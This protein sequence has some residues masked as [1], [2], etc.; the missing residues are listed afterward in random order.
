MSLISGSDWSFVILLLIVILSAL[1]LMVISCMVR[2]ETTTMAKTTEI[3]NKILQ[4][5]EEGKHLL[6]NSNKPF[7][8]NMTMR[9]TRKRK[10]VRARPCSAQVSNT[11]VS[12]KF[13]LPAKQEVLLRVKFY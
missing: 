5:I 7:T 6:L 3:S 4:D 1:T 10:S 12:S 11:A 8:R 2:R 13:K 9:A